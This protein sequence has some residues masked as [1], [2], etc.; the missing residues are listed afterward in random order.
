MQARA[1]PVAERSAQDLGEHVLRHR[2]LGHLESHIAAMADHLRADLD[3]LLAQA[4]QRSRCSLAA[5]F[6]GRGTPSGVRNLSSWFGALR[7]PGLKPR[8]PSR[9]KV[10]FIRFMMRE[11]WLTGL[12]RSLL[13]RLASS[14]ESVGI[15]ANLQ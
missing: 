12:S 5:C 6:G 15:V 14:S 11:R 8:M 3:Q 2:N 4:D 13:G 10:P 9:A 7:K 1:V